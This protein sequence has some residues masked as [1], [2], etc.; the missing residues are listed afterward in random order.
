MALHGEFCLQFDEGDIARAIY[1]PEDEVADGFDALR[2]AVAA[3]KRRLWRSG[4]TSAG[5]TTA[6][7]SLPPRR[8]APPLADTTFRFRRRQQHVHAGRAREPSSSRLTSFCQP[9]C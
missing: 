9:Q 8:S 3:L 4:V 7:R 5:R 6:R 2:A 1:D